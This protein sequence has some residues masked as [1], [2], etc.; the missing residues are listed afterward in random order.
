MSGCGIFVGA[1]PMR[2]EQ[3]G[4][5]TLYLGD[6][7]EVLPTLGKVDA[8]VTDPPYGNANHDGDWNARLNDHR[9]IIGQPIANDTAPEMRAVMDA[10]LHE[11]ARL[12]DK[13]ASAC[14]CFCSGGGPRPVFAWLAERMDRDGLAFFHSLVWDKRNPGLGQR[15]RRQHE[16]V[17]IAHRA[18]GRIR[19]NADD[20]KVPNVMSGMPPR[21]REHPNE[22]P[23]EIIEQ[24]VAT[25]SNAGDLI[26]DPFM[27]SGTTLRAAKD[28]GRK[29]IGIE[30]EEKYCEIAA[31]RL[32]QEVLP[33]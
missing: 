28:L 9:G 14:C 5:A 20:R 22:K 27:G 2:V 29:C 23:V 32:A 13:R 8:V 21:D 10:M 16:M 19:W 12:L 18:G 1:R 6:C 11:A 24:I 30:I 33:L 4:A 15:Y 7:R 3:I 31:K 17:M 26:L 25:H